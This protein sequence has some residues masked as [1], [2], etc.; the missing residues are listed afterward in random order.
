MCMHSNECNL[1]HALSSDTNVECSKLGYISNSITILAHLL[2]YVYLKT[3]RPEDNLYIAQN[4]FYKFNLKYF[5]SQQIFGKL[6]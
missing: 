2:T 1:R 5:L 3:A 4:Q 6:H